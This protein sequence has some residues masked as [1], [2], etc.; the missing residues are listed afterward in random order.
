MSVFGSD[1]VYQCGDVTDACIQDPETIIEEN[2]ATIEET[3]E[4]IDRQ[5]GYRDVTVAARSHVDM[6]ST[7]L[8]TAA[9]F[10]YN[11]PL[12]NCNAF[13]VNYINFLVLLNTVSDGNIEMVKLYNAAFD[14]APDIVELCSPQQLKDLKAKADP[15]IPEVAV[16]ISTY[17]SSKENEIKRLRTVLEKY[18]EK[19]KDANEMLED[20]GKPTIPPPGN[21]V[22]ETIIESA[23]QK[24]GDAK[25][26]IIKIDE[27][28]T[29][30]SFSQT[31]LFL[32]QLSQTTEAQERSG[33][34][35]ALQSKIG[36]FL[37]LLDD[38]RD[39]NIQDIINYDFPSYSAAVEEC[40]T[41]AAQLREELKN[42]IIDANDRLLVYGNKKV[43][44]KNAYREDIMKAL[45]EIQEANNDLESDGKPTVTPPMVNFPFPE[46]TPTTTESEA[47]DFEDNV[48]IVV[49]EK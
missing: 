5:K 26:E 9:A 23:V 37:A 47:E 34:C 46:T 33:S 13:S 3:M 22:P 17:K 29:L 25:V 12:D 15:R 36:E 19:I 7:K 40:G 6:I 21:L 11:N 43:E 32:P 27:L 2:I 31:V 24:I 4:E 38:L 10:R 44:E 28:K 45:E 1:Y 39:E 42:E 49:V 48:V 20:E 30:V 18:L 14:E 8:K 41:G 16:K 35:E